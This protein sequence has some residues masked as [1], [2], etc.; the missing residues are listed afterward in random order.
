MPLSCIALLSH[1][2][3]ASLSH[4]PTPHGLSILPR[5]IPPSIPSRQATPP[6]L[7]RGDTRVHVRAVRHPF[8]AGL[9]AR[10]GAP[11]L[12][13]PS[14]RGPRPSVGIT[15]SRPPSTASGSSTHAHGYQGQDGLLVHAQ[16][17]SRPATGGSMPYPRREQSDCAASAPPLVRSPW[18]CLHRKVTRDHRLASQ[19]RW[20]GR[21]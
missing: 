15:E 1:H 20:W 2:N 11:L 12:R 4:C 21:E 18:A 8:I 5:F 6:P 19:T 16:A 9:S 14:S 7:P 10:D 3:R 13:A 17:G